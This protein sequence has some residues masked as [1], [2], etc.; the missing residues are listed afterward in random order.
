MVVF[1]QRVERR[2]A[3]GTACTD[4]A[5]LAFEPHEALEQQGHAAECRERASDVARRSEHALA[6]AVVPEASRLEHGGQARH[7][8]GALEVGL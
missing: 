1:D 3:V 2:G 6:L 4:E 5:E 7:R 8:D